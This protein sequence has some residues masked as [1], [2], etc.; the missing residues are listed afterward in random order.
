MT[1]TKARTEV[2]MI[3]RLRKIKLSARIILAGYPAYAKV[4]SP[5][6]K[7]DDRNLIHVCPR[8]ALERK[9]EIEASGT[10]P[11]RQLRD[12]YFEAGVP[13]C[14]ASKAGISFR[15]F[16]SLSLTLLSHSPSSSF[17]L[18]L[19]LSFTRSRMS[20]TEKGAR[21]FNEPARKLW[22]IQWFMDRRWRT[23]PWIDGAVD[24][25]CEWQAD[26]RPVWH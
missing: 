24:A 4:A 21:G 3:L 11:V 19:F 23:A 18:S 12:F 5:A 13:L 1:E 6:R 10:K 7:T 22:I 15:F 20:R 25:T 2:Q 17:P 14:V 26:L 8:I 16:F 9:R